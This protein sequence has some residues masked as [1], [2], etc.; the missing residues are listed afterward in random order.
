MYRQE[1]EN[2]EVKTSGAC[3]RQTR[4]DS[5]LKNR[6]C[7]CSV[8]QWNRQHRGSWIFPIFP[9]HLY[10]FQTISN[11]NHAISII[12]SFSISTVADTP[13]GAKYRICSCQHQGNPRP[14]LS[15]G[16]MMLHVRLNWTWRLDEI[17]ELNNVEQKFMLIL[18]VDPLN[19]EFGFKSIAVGS[20]QDT[21]CGRSLGLCG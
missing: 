21:P 15:P 3:R 6:L 19:C 2:F 9:I 17:N 13:S 4:A 18:P 14:S 1:L 10:S 12:L 16:L 7:E 5:I 11:S 20:G 8:C